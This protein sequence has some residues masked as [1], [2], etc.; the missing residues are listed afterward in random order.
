MTDPIRW[1]ILA[2]GAI[3]KSFVED[4]RLVPDA[5]VAAV[6]SRSLDTALA[7]AARHDIPRGYGSWHELAT[8]PEIDVIYVATPHSA[9]L[10]AAMTCV[11]AG[12][13]TLVEKPLTLNLETARALTRA[14]SDAAIFLM[15]AVWTRFFPVIHQIS[16]LIADGA[17]GEVTAVHA[18]FGLAGPYPPGSRLLDPRL[19]G[20]ALLDLGIYPVTIAHLFLGAPDEISARARLTPEGVD[21]NTAIT[22]GYASGAFAQLSCSL[23]GDSAQRATVTGTKGRIE[24][25]RGFFHPDHF[26]LVR[27]WGE[28]EVFRTPF[29]GH[30]YHYE[31]AEV[32][33]CLRAGWTESPMLPHAETLA[34]MATLDTA[35][36]KIG[37]SYDR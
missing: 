26:A 1:G 17:I 7:F 5:V 23:V 14:A 25:P 19:G 6:G 22:L 34:V 2:T 10:D 13:A 30:G 4:L 31:I 15:E 36:A 16:A 9:H 32:Q 24:L 20:G 37:V 35:L 29:D 11:C 21:E 12:T 27:N 18:D 8:D 28:P 3:A 33:R